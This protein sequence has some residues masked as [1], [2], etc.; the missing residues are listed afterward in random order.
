MTQASAR[1]D[2]VPRPNRREHPPRRP[3]APAAADP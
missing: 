1:P 2:P 3:K